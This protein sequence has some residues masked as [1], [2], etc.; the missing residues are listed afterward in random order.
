MYKCITCKP[1]KYEFRLGILYKLHS[2]TVDRSG[3]WPSSC[4]INARANVIPITTTRKRVSHTHARDIIIYMCGAHEN[5]TSEFHTLNELLTHTHTHTL[6]LSFTH[7]FSLSRTLSLSF[8]SAVTIQW[9]YFDTPARLTLVWFQRQDFQPFFSSGRSIIIILRHFICM[10]KKHVLTSRDY[11]R[12]PTTKSAYI[13]SRL[14]QLFI[15]LTQNS[16]AW[17]S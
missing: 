3:Y 7:V 12:Q 8:A 4:R 16:G 17:I 2:T 15:I 13:G 9:N 1:Y 11:R 14:Q 10:F 5:I 6:F